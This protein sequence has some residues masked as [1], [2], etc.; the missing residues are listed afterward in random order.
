MKTFE[1][2]FFELLTKFLKILFPRVLLSLIIQFIQKCDRKSI[3]R[4]RIIIFHSRNAV[5]RKA[6]GEQRDNGR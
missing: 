1:K 2:Q 5:L 3:V 6:N 4:T